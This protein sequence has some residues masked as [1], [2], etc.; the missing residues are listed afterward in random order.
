MEYR[1]VEFHKIK[2]TS[3]GGVE[4]EYEHGGKFHRQK[5]P[6]MPAPEFLNCLSRLKLHLIRI[7]GMLA[8]KS[9]SSFSELTQ[10][11]KGYLST[12]KDKVKCTGASLKGSAE[13]GS[14]VIMGTLMTIEGRNVAI[15]TPLINFGSQGYPYANEIQTECELL[16]REAY[17]YLFEGKTATPALTDDEGNPIGNEPGYVPPLFPDGE[18]KTETEA[19]DE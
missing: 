8:E 7:Y 13:S 2:T 5:S 15:N 3:N 12:V 16:V 17:A 6:D 9:M 4:V 10:K 11:E 19:Q 1:D 18:P 14:A